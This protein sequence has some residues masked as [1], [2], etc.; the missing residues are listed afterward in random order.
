MI[1]LIE[2]LLKFKI[3]IDKVVDSFLSLDNLCAHWLHHFYLLLLQHVSA[4]IILLRLNSKIL[5]KL[6]DL[7]FVLFFENRILFT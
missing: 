7:S 4:F 5:R 3:N 1:E 6:F 2:V